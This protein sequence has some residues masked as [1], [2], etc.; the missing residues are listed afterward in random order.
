MFFSLFEYLF[1]MDMDFL[2]FPED[3]SE[4]IRGFFVLLIFMIGALLAMLFFHTHSKKEE[5][6]YD[7]KFKDIHRYEEDDKDN[8]EV[9][10]ENAKEDNE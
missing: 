4:Y 6:Y 7:H 1:F 9:V 5:K 10:E 8:E 3:K 2:Y